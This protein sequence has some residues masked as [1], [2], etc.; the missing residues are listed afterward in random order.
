M[1]LPDGHMERV[2]STYSC[3]PFDTRTGSVYRPQEEERNIHI[4]ICHQPWHYTYGSAQLVP[5]GWPGR[6]SDQIEWRRNKNEHFFILLKGGQ[7]THANMAGPA[8]ST[9]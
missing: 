1:G 9:L 6:K 3:Q 2:P 5:V 7:H 8:A 4:F